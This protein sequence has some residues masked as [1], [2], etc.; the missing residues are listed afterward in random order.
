MD[1]CK[2]KTLSKAKTKMVEPTNEASP[3]RNKACFNL[4]E[5]G[6]E[7]NMSASPNPD[8]ANPKPDMTIDLSLKTWVINKEEEGSDHDEIP[9]GINHF[10][11][12][13]CW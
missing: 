4:D 7:S 2:N 6:P 3:L 1:A 11:K 9:K 5:T 10:I 12:Y 13:S 8:K